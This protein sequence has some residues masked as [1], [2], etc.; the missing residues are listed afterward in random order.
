MAQVAL[1]DQKG[2]DQMDRVYPSFQSLRLSFGQP[3]QSNGWHGNGYRLLRYMAKPM[4]AVSRPSPKTT[5]RRTRPR[6]SSA[7]GPP[8][9]RHRDQLRQQV[10]KRSL[11]GISEEEI[12]A[13]FAGMPPRYWDR[14]TLTELVWGLRMVHCFLNDVVA[15]E[16]AGPA[17]V[18]DWRQL[19]GQRFTKVLVCAWDGLGL[20]TKVAGYISAMRLNVARA[21]VYT[22]SDNIVLDVF[23]LCDAKH[24]QIK[25]PDRLRQL[26]FLLKGGLSNP[27]RFASTWACDSHK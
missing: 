18:I 17:V 25:D 22:R 21:Q 19:P 24:R 26:A 27:P 20:L 15:A 16:T 12:D 2:T 5:R 1:Q 4:K 23:W 3:R 8:W 11:E 13:H 9:Q 7:A 10:S 14:L 6:A